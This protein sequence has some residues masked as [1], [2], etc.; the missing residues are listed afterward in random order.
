MNVRKAA[1]V[2]GCSPQHVRTLIRSGRLRGR[3]VPLT[4]QSKGSEPRRIGFTWSI[5]R[6][7][8][9]RFAALPGD[10]KGRG[11]PRGRPR[12]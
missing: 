3:K 12:V 7:E 9:E 10:P 1:E 4:V 8:V 6:A 11:Y 2:L 5:T